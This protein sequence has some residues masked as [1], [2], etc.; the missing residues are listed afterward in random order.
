[1]RTTSL[2]KLWEEVGKVAERKAGR[3]GDQAEC[4]NGN[5]CTCA[6]AVQQDHESPDRYDRDCEK[7]DT[8]CHS[9]S[10]DH[11]T[12]RS[13]QQTSSAL[14]VLAFEIW[15]PNPMWK[16]GSAERASCSPGRASAM[17]DDRGV[18]IRLALGNEVV[19]HPISENVG[20]AIERRHTSVGS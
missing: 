16:T 18:G 5:A 11:A 17:D 12:R 4:G 19:L 2:G 10:V 8:N 1:M 20:V 7:G 9:Q 13:G 14:P 6:Q 15:A 3:Y